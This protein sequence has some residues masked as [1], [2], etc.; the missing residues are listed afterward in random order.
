MGESFSGGDGAVG[1]VSVMSCDRSEDDMKE[2]VRCCAFAQTCSPMAEIST[3]ILQ[4][5]HLIVGNR[6]AISMSSAI[7]AHTDSSAP[8]RA[9]DIHTA[10]P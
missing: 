10:K 4:F 3:A 6:P 7:T 1:K 8:H 5:E 2:L 9:L